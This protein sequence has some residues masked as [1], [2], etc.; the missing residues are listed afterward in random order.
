MTATTTRDPSPL[1]ARSLAAA[2][3]TPSARIVLERG[4]EI[5]AAEVGPELVHEHELRVGSL[6]EQEVRDPE[7]ARGSDQEI[8]IGHVRLVQKG[9]ESLLVEP[10]R[11]H[12]RLERAARGFDDLRAAAVIERDPELQPVLV[13]GRC[14]ELGHLV[15]QRHGRAVAAAYE[16]GADT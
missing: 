5:L 13:R 3:A 12:S 10:L 15:L 7:L 8:R 16:T 4:A 14:L 2:E 11:S 1:T 9:R 6:P